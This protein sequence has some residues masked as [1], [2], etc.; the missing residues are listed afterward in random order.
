MIRVRYTH[1]DTGNQLERWM[2][3][4][5]FDSWFAR[6]PKSVRETCVAVVFDDRD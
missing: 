5:A 4:D 3:Q 1:P 6:A 2:D